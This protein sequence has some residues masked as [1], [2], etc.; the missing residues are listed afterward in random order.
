MELLRAL[1]ALCE[2]PAPAHR[3]IAC[4]LGLPRVPDA[5]EWTRLFALELPPYA[6]I[7]LGAEGMIG[8]EA[9]ARTAGFWTALGLL[10]PPEPDHLAALLGLA[11]ALGDAE[12]DERDPARRA[13]RREA[14]GALLWEHLACW[15]P[16]YLDR[17]EPLA[18]EGYR[19][20][21]RL[22]GEAL[23]ELAAELS[24]PRVLPA[25][26]RTAPELKLD[27]GAGLDE[28]VSALLVPVRSGLILTRADLRRAASELGL[29]LRS[30]DRRTAVRTLLAQDPAETCGWRGAEARRTAARPSPSWLPGEIRQFWRERAEH[31][32]AVLGR[33][34]VAAGGW[35]ARERRAA[36]A[37]PR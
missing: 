36:T 28:I 31:A 17:L 34:S 20:W 10:P 18:S 37:T 3:A 2:A 19:E 33:L 1:G 12:R 8:G 7:Y 27:A 4:H 15:L 5:E 29:G 25:Q 24:P 23:G 21:A 35:A 6:S 14:R 32:A 13:L 30:G 11:A 9:Q 26:L 16:P 22:L